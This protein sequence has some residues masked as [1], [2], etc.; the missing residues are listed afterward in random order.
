MVFIPIGFFILFFMFC[1]AQ[2]SNLILL[3]N[4]RC[5]DGTVGGFYLQNN[6]TVEGGSVFV[7]HFQGSTVYLVH[8]VSYY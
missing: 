4:A 3:S 6:S 8:F 1:H 2:I 7:I 5:M